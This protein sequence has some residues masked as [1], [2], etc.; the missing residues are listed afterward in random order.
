MPGRAA[1]GRVIYERIIGAWIFLCGITS[2]VFVAMIFLFVF[3]EAFPLFREFPAWSFLTGKEWRPTDDPAAFGLVPLLLSSLLVTAGAIV[4][5]VPLGISSAIFIGEIA[6]A[7]LRDLLKTT[8]ELL[9]SVPSVVLG[10]FGL[11]VLGPILQQV[12]RMDIGT[13]MLAGSITLA[14]MAIPTIATISEDALGTVA[15][16]IRE[17]SLG[18]GATRWQTI[19]GVVVPAASS[20]IVAATMLGVGRA[21]GETMVVL[22]VTGNGVGQNLTALMGGPQNPLAVFQQTFGA[23][24]E[25]CRTLTATIAAEMGEVTPGEAHYHALFLLGV[26]LFAITFLVNL[27]ADAALRRAQRGSR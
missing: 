17:G 21:I 13:N 27:A 4:I 3:R 19:R 11:A 18:L 2:I 12:F 23:Y 8:V 26:V 1:R 14:F 5:A 9:A 16:D 15:R 24:A 6:P 25:V 20:G 10:F 22:M 7:R